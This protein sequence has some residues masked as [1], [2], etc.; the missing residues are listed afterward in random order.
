MWEQE[1]EIL[2]MEL[3]HQLGLEGDQ[4]DV[5]LETVWQEAGLQK[6]VEKLTE[7]N[8]LSLIR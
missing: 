6:K 3:K 7:T 2:S 5:S 1:I 4:Q 8:T